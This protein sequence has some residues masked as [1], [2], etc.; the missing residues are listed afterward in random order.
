MKNDEIHEFTRIP[1]SCKKIAP[2]RQRVKTAVIQRYFNHSGAHFLPQTSQ[3]QFFGVSSAILLKF[4]EFLSISLNSWYF[5]EIQ[6]F[7]APAA[8]QT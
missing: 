1:Q 8:S 2:L 6:G 4:I 3:N 5:T 7:S